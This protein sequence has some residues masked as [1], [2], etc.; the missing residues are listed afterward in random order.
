MAGERQFE[1]AAE[2]GAVDRGDPRLAG[3]FDA[4]EQQRQ[5][6]AFVE[7]RV[8]G[9]D[10]ALRRDKLGEA[11]A[12]AFQHRQI[13]AGAERVL[14]RGDDDA[15]DRRVGRK[16]FDD[17]RQLLDRRR[18]ETFIERPGNIPG[19]ERNAVAVG[20]ELEIVEGSSSSFLTHKARRTCGYSARP[21]RR[22]RPSDRYRDN[23]RARASRACRSREKPRR[24][25]FVDELMAVAATGLEARGVA[26]LE[27]ASR[28]RPRPARLRPRACKRT[29]L[30]SRA[31]AA[32]PTPRPA[33][34]SSD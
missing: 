25:R 4:A 20:L 13:G 34:A 3:G 24:D 14:A 11:A 21:C 27:H 7:Q 32:A 23:R 33:S 17:R 6:A 10:L 28:R 16:L 1:A 31:S 12:Q 22:G 5:F 30:P 29:R 18:V 15:L 9:R 19:D 2:R 8:V 26:R